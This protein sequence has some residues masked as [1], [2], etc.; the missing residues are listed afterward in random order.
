MFLTI[1]SFTAVAF[2]SCD[3]FEEKKTTNWI[4]NLP[5]DKADWEVTN[6]AEEFM[7]RYSYAILQDDWNKAEQVDNEMRAYRNGLTVSD[8]I[9]FDQA[10]DEY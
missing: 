2:T 5:T 8:Q 1:A 7:R 4:N 9:V 3:A 10:I 6:K